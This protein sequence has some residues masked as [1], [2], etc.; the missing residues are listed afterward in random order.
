MQNGLP[1]AW[2]DSVVIHRLQRKC[3]CI[4]CSKQLPQRTKWDT[5]SMLKGF[6]EPI[7]Q[8]HRG[9][10]HKSR[11]EWGARGVFWGYC[12]IKD[13]TQKKKVKQGDRSLLGWDV[14]S[15]SS[16]W[17]LTWRQHLLP[18]LCLLPCFPASTLG[19]ALPSHSDWRALGMYHG[20]SG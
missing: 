12:N 2:I 8:L 14:S 5:S 16:S 7:Q 20:S 3:H 13:Q 15:S 1:S 17:T 6:A 19:F 18:H 11:G 4:V 9:V 10:Q